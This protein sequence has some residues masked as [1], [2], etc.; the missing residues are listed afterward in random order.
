MLTK[1]ADAIVGGDGDDTISG[2][3]AAT[4]EAATDTLNVTDVIDGGAGTDTMTAINSATNTGALGEAVV[5]NVEV[6]NIRQPTAQPR[7]VDF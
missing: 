7:C 3:S 1:D 6:F 5:T 4:A 2:V